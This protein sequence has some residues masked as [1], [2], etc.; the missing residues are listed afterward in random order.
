MSGIAS[1]YN[2][3]STDEELTTWAFLH[4]AHHADINRVIQ[5][6]QGVQ[7]SAPVLNPFDPNDMQEWLDQHQILH[8]QMN[9]VLGISGF[10]LDEVDFNAEGQRAGWIWL[11]GQEHQQAGTKTGID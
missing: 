1:L 4:A 8:Q 6:T 9:Q 3:P 2:V 5:Q 7:L 10:N 11:N